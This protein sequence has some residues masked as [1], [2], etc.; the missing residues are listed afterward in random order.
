MG[1][2]ETKILKEYAQNIKL[3]ACGCGKPVVGFVC[4]RTRDNH[5]LASSECGARYEKEHKPD[6]GRV[7]NTAN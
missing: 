6:Y 5:P 2:K 3:C 7:V 4:Y 1:F